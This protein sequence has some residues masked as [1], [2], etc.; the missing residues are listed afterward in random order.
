M[1][2][3]GDHCPPPEHA[4]SPQPHAAPMQSPYAQA[5]QALPYA[6]QVRTTPKEEREAQRAVASNWELF[7]RKQEASES[8]AARQ[9]A[10]A[11]R[12]RRRRCPRR[13]VDGAGRRVAPGLVASCGQAASSD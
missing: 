3:H 7:A 8:S 13:T 10:G 1:S 6:K 9:A 5:F 4:P 11:K 2:S 12:T